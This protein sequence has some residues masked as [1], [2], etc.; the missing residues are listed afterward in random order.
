QLNINITR[1]SY[2]KAVDSHTLFIDA[3]GT[4][5]QLKKADIELEK[6]GYL[7]SDT[8]KTSIVLVEFRLSDVP[9]SVTSVLELI[10][11][12][13][14]NI[15]YISSQE[16]GTDYQYFKMGLYVEDYDKVS[17]FLKEAEKLCKVRVIDYNSSE[18]VYDNSI[19]YNTYVLGLSQTMGLSEDVSRELLVHVNLAMQT[20]DEQGLSPYRTFDSISKFAELLGA[21]KGS[22]FNPRIST[23]KITDNTEI[24]LIEPPCGSN[25]IIIKSND[26]ILFVDSGYACYSDEMIRIFKKIV[27]DFENM[28]KTILVTHADVDHCG[29]LPMF[30]KIIASSKTAT[31]L[32]REYEGKNGYRE[33]NPL[34]RPYINICKI[35]TSYKA[36]NPEKIT[37]MWNDVENPSEPLTQIGFFDF[38]ELHFEVYE[39]KGGHLPGE[40][41][42]IDYSKHIA[43]TGDVYINM[44]G[45][46]AEQ[47]EYNQYA[48]ILM[49][50]VDTDSK[51]CLEERKAIMQ[52]LGVGQWQIFGAHGFKKDYSVN[53]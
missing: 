9:G 1:V 13:N 20:L 32:Q 38:E 37:A 10:N 30:D 33:E 36:V 39:G 8:N 29:L 28:E 15:S 51:L 6:I 18:K 11:E 2:N 23:H 19:F 41:V 31:C 43:I 21:S 40:I 4:E 35:L 5:E 46:T 7:Q 14:F 17:E 50:S 47:A 26:K 3:E 22:S 48:P 53:S 12:F 24:T 34:H 49:T 52:R 16:N 44:H 42:L 45:L 27:P 25:T